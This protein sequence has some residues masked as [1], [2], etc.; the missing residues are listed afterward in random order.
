MSGR[1]DCLL[2]APNESRTH[3]VRS[4]MARAIGLAV[5]DCPSAAR[6]STE[7]KAFAGSPLLG[8]TAGG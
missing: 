4:T 8:P 1:E 5:G 3:P 6:D 2:R 7:R